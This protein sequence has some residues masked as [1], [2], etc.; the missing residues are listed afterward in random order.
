MEELL[1]LL[2]MTGGGLLVNEAYDRLGDIGDKAWDR[3]Q[4]IG[5]TASNATQFT[6]YG[7][8]GP[9]GTSTVD[10]S[11]NL[12]NTLSPEQQAYADRLLGKSNSMMAHDN[13]LAQYGSNAINTAKGLLG[14][15]GQGSDGREQYYYDQIRAM[16]TPEEERQRL[17][18]ENRL[19]SQG[20]LGVRTAAY[21]GTPE[22]LALSKAQEEAQNTASVQAIELA[23]QQQLQ[24]AQIA[25]ALGTSGTG[26]LTTQG[27]L[28]KL[29]G[30]MQYLPQSSLLDQFNAGTQA[31]GYE[32]IARRQGANQYAEAYMGG[33]EGLLGAG[34][35][36]ANLMGTLGSSLLGGG[37]GMLGSAI[38]N[39]NIESFGGLWDILKGAF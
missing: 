39:N 37:F 34:L 8:T 1:A 25:Q 7:V 30:T 4:T 27:D 18:L 9:S 13:Y 32:D 36:Q 20:R 21:G 33:L 31:Y 26:A 10:A 28:A 14:Q 19:A 6:G 12:T 2:G 16:Q 15:I 23:R 22:Q 17:G 35:G 29:Y 5:D 24:Q 3:S 38:S 11:G